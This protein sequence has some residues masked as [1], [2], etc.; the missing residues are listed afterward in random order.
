MTNTSRF[1]LEKFNNFGEFTANIIFS[2]FLSDSNPIRS[3]ISSIS[4]YGVCLAHVGIFVFFFASLH[5]VLHDWFYCPK[6]IHQ[7][8]NFAILILIVLPNSVHRIWIPI[9][10]VNFSFFVVSLLLLHY[11]L[12]IQQKW[13]ERVKQYLKILYWSPFLL[14][15]VIGH[16]IYE[17]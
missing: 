9:A 15:I 1:F 14:S 5:K 17:Q 8:I 4:C 16:F 2:Y 10:T 7:I 3:T 11:H 12:Q 13:A 6:A